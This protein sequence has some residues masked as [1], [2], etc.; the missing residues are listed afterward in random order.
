LALAVSETDAS[1]Q[2]VA[3][4]KFQQHGLNPRPVRGTWTR[5]EIVLTLGASSQMTATLDGVPALAAPPVVLDPSWTNGDVTVIVGFAY[6][7][8]IGSTWQAL[9]DDVTF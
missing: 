6:I 2:E 5:V 7:T 8:A 9:F 4:A 1:I 3:G